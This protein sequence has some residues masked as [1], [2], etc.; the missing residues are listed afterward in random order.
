MHYAAPILEASVF[1]SILG[2]HVITIIL[3]H[4]ALQF[5][6]KAKSFISAILRP[7]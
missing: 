2:S 5:S 3:E 4:D 1:T 7:K 6:L